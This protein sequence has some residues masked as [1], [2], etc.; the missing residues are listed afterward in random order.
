MRKAVCLSAAAMLVTACAGS[1]EQVSA[2]PTTPVSTASISTATSDACRTLATSPD[3]QAVQSG[4]RDGMDQVSGLAILGAFHAVRVMENASSTY[5]GLDVR[6]ADVMTDAAVI[7]SSMHRRYA[8]DGRFDSNGF[9][10]ML[11]PVVAAC[12][13]A[14][15]SMTPSS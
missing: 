6:V 3:I 12:R 15:V 8:T 1:A 9:T 4:I 10:A 2:P 5:Q 11:S 13:S 14:G 7:A